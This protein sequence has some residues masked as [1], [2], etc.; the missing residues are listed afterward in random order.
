MITMQIAR[1]LH[2]PKLCFGTLWTSINHHITH[3]LDKSMVKPYMFG[4]SSA[5][6]TWSRSCQCNARRHAEQLIV[7]M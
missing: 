6:D 3:L 7:H 1:G 2:A 4:Y 5:I